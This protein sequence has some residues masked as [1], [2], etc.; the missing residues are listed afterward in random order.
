MAKVPFYPNFEISKEPEILFSNTALTLYSDLFEELKD[1]NYK[2]TKVIETK[3]SGIIFT[4]FQFYN[5]NFHK[6]L[7]KHHIYSSQY[8]GDDRYKVYGLFDGLIDQCITLNENVDILSDKLKN[9]LKEQEKNENKYLIL[10]NEINNMKLLELKNK[11]KELGL[12]CSGSKYNLI[13][14]I[15]KKLLKYDSNDFILF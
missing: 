2:L 10:I 11:C 3:K 8:M 4:F 13:E 12:K 5:N 14:S 15:L 7:I 6:Y 1:N 9:N